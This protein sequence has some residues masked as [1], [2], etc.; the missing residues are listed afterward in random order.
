VDHLEIVSGGQIVAKF[1]GRVSDTTV[2]LPVAT[3]TWFIARAYSDRPR[4]PVLDLYPFSSTSPVYVHVGTAP[5]SCRDDAEFFL[6]WI[7]LLGQRVRSDTSWN[8]PAERERTLAL[9]SRAHEEFIRR[10]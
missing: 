10:R 9:I 6:R 4:L 1:S 3:S 5:P 2:T 7:N 8:T